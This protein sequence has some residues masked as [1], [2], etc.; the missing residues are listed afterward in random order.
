MPEV[1][2]SVFEVEEKWFAEKKKDLE[3]R[4]AFAKVL[5]NAAA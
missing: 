3:M 5:T 1:L 2:C 4:F